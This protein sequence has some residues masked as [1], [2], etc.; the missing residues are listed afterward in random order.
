MPSFSS[1]RSLTLAFLLSLSLFLSTA[2]ACPNCKDS[3]PN[4]QPA[5]TDGAATPQVAQGYAWS[6]Y[7]MLAVPFT[8]VAAL[9]GAAY[10]VSK[11]AA[12]VTQRL[13]RQAP[14]SSSARQGEGHPRAG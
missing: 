14:T 2:Q 8:L 7:F 1:S 13:S 12:Q 5:S 10:V 4:G 6:I 9:G 3:L 11:R